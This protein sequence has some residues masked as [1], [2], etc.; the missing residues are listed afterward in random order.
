MW[1]RLLLLIAIW[2][3]LIGKEIKMVTYE[4]L[5]MTVANATVVREAAGKIVTTA[6]KLE[7]MAAA[8]KGDKLSTG[9]ASRLLSQAAH[10]KLKARLLET[11]LDRML[12]LI[13]EVSRNKRSL[14]NVGGVLRDL[15]GVASDDDRRK[16]EVK[17]EDKIKQIYKVEKA[18]K[19]LMAK[20]MKKE[21]RM[22]MSNTHHISTMDASLTRVE[23][24]LLKTGVEL[25]LI[26]EMAK[27]ENVVESLFWTA[28]GTLNNIWRLVDKA[29]LGRISIDMISEEDLEE[30]NYQ[31]VHF[32]PGLR[33]AFD[34]IRDI[35]RMYTTDIVRTRDLLQI[36]M[37]IPY[38]DTGT[39]EASF[40]ADE[41]VLVGDGM[42]CI[43][44]PPP[45][46]VNC[47]DGICRERLCQV[48]KPTACTAKKPRACLTDSEL[49]CRQTNPTTYEI[50]PNEDLS[51]TVR[52]PGRSKEEHKMKKKAYYTLSISNDCEVNEALI[53]ITPLLLSAENTGHGASRLLSEEASTLDR[54]EKTMTETSSNLNETD[55][56]LTSLTASLDSF[57]MTGSGSMLNVTNTWRE[58][59]LAQEEKM[60][61]IS[62]DIENMQDDGFIPEAIHEH[63]TWA[64]STV[65]FVILIILLITLIC[66][67]KKFGFLREQIGNALRNVTP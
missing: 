39:F 63:T 29:M 49:L 14:I 18:D 38:T 43:A 16:D 44:S 42:F 5:H 30:M 34:N 57:N 11:E 22:I 40:Y 6:E 54:M 19:R 41:A 2:Q 25:Q 55:K 53:V 9:E 67:R 61:D 62:K 66:V 59:K 36:S 3:I 45:Q 31:M 4:L 12:V 56:R 27:L 58:W 47:A 10:H 23:K 15:L 7:K 65:V 8:H 32:R 60:Q 37:R 1:L 21:D 64:T 20:I 35:L 28:K 51:I 26:M 33:P 17:L 24:M 50:L 52:C 48:R 46:W 13:P